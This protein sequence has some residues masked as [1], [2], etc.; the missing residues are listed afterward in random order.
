[1]VSSVMIVT[2]Y[3]ALTMFLIHPT[4]VT[5]RFEWRSDLAGN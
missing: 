5:T 3:S 1:V 4:L 2:S